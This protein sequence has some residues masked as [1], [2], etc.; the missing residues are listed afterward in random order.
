MKVDFGISSSVAGSLSASS[1]SMCLRSA[2]PGGEK[3]EIE[4]KEG[5]FL[6]EYTFLQVYTTIRM[7][8]IIE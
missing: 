4:I 3:G 6:L 8:R 1:I 7:L 5:L 2:L